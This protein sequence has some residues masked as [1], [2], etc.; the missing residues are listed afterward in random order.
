MLSSQDLAPEILAQHEGGSGD[1]ASEANPVSPLVRMKME[2]RPRKRGQPGFPASCALVPYPRWPHG[3]SPGA[4]QAGAE[5][6]QARPTRFRTGRD[7]WFPFS[8]MSMAKLEWYTYMPRS[9][10]GLATRGA[11]VWYLGY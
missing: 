1:L 6:S 11:V 7:P 4:H 5:T 3:P 2:R 9:K 8:R 10:I